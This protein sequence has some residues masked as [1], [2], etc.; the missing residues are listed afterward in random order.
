MEDN[1]QDIPASPDIEETEVQVSEQP[2]AS[3]TQESEGVRSLRSERERLSRENKELLNRLKIAEE[4]RGQAQPNYDP[5]DYVPRQYVDNELKSIKKQ[6]QEASIKNNYPDFDKVV[7]DSTIGLL[8]ENNPALAYAISQVGDTY[9]QA[10]AVYEAIKNLG[11]YTE[12][13]FEKDRNTAQ[14][15]ANKPKPLQAVTPQ[16]Q[17]TNSPLS[18]ANAFAEG[19]EEYRNQLWK[20]MNFYR[21]K[22]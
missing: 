17:K 3:Q 1:L 15:N 14:Q 10:S 5:D 19:S 21:K 6:L 11:L 4:Q 13:K 7:N 16:N 18:H 8:K 2:Q 9:S 22:M 20:E 12:D